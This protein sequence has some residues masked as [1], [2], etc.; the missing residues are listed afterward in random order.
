MLCTLKFDDDIRENLGRLPPKLEE[1]YAAVYAKL[2]SHRGKLGRSIIENTFKWLLSARRT[3]DASKFLWAVAL[4]LD[5]H[6]DMESILD[7]CHNLVIHDEGLDI[8][9]FAHLSVRE[10][11][12]KRSE[13]S[14]KSCNALAAENCLTHMIASSKSSNAT[15]KLR[16]SHIHTIHERL[17]SAEPSM[18]AGF[19]DYSFDVWMVHCRLASRD[20][21]LGDSNFGQTFRF[22]LSE[23]PMRDSAFD[24]WVQ[25]YSNTL[26]IDTFSEKGKPGSRWPL[27]GLLCRYPNTTLRIF[28]IAVAYGFSEITESYLQNKSLGEEE[29]KQ[30]IL[31]AAKAGQKEVCG[32]LMN[33][34]NVEL[35]SEVLLGLIENRDRQML[36]GLRSKVPSS[37]FTEQ[38]CLTA[39][40]IEDEWYLDWLLEQYPQLIV[41]EDM[42]IRA[43]GT[44]YAFELLFARTASTMPLNKV[45]MEAIRRDAMSEITFILA[46]AGSSCLS[47]TLMARAADRCNH[48]ATMEVLL[49]HG[50]ASMISEDV[51]VNVARD[52]S[53]EMLKLILV[54][55]G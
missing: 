48:I 25:R 50:G 16:K 49:A 15:F 45:L 21:R 19:M 27:H 20:A 54:H 41:T 38:T 42:L 9:R 37:C 29:L 36:E 55:G 47:S 2:T 43:I 44:T 6:V 52:H 32:L 5:T 10:F 24:E 23:V 18:R 39:I 3:L 17:I 28:F 40:G 12:E 46:R 34:K 1:L 13:F 4:N 11:L 31:L 53:G 26:P 14:Q 51:L 7:L 8:F 22:F 33:S 30:A 35:T